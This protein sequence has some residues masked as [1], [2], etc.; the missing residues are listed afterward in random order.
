MNE[1]QKNREKIEGALNEVAANREIRAMGFKE[2]AKEY[3]E[4][5][6]YYV[7][8]GF[9]QEESLKILLTEISKV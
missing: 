2:V 4:K 5:Y 1:I 6:R 8:A 3:F 9:T 7:E